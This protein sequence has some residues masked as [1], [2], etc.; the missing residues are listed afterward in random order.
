MITLT[1]F[2]IPFIVAIGAFIFFHKEKFHIHE[3]IIQLSI[4]ALVAIITSFIIT[5]G[6][7]KDSEIWNGR[8]VNKISERVS[9]SH[10]Y[11]C[12]PHPCMCDKN[13]CQTC[14]DTCYD[15]SY[16]IDWNLY[17]N[18][19]E[20]ITIGRI[21][22]QGLDQ[23]LRWTIART[24]DTTSINHDYKNYV[25]AN[26]DSLFAYD[27]NLIKKY[28][29]KLL[30][31]PNNIYDYHYLNR[32]ID[33]SNMFLNSV[34]MINDQLSYLNSDLGSLKQVN[35]ILGIVLD[36]EEDFFDAQEQYWKGGKKNDV[37]LI[38]SIDKDK[39]IL[40]AKV[41][42]FSKNQMI[43]VSL[44]DDIEKLKNIKSKELEIINIL[45]RNVIYYYNRKPMS[46]FDYLKDS[47]Q[48]TT[49]QFTVSIII[50]LIISVILSIVF[51][52]NDFN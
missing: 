10:S 43:K 2:F 17:T 24:G 40:W 27:K 23:P 7:T 25:K 3:L 37:I 9:C 26:P 47:I 44:R 22:R 48:P 4:S 21:D 32:F 18:N 11:P 33:R 8:I 30:S 29:N 52:K 36:K 50:N 12:N 5:L 28:K 19:M 20:K 34:K 31:Y 16:D 15:H 1:L 14:W 41:M 35:V 13:G 46:D 45:R 38:I 6:D 51:I 49:T 42:A 39:N